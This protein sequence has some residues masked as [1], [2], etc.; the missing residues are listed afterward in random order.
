[1][2]PDPISAF[3]SALEDAGLIP[4]E[5]I[6]DGNLHRCPTRGKEHRKDGAY[7]LH[8]DP[9]ISGWWQNYRTGASDTW[10]SGDQATLPEEERS[11]LRARIEADKKARQ[12]EDVRRHANARNRAIH[13]LEQARKAPQ[14]HPYLVRKGITPV[15][16]LLV[17]SDKKLVI[18]V[19]DATNSL[20]SLQF[21]TVT[22]E[23]KFLS[24]GKI[25]GCFFPIRGGDGP[26]H[27][28]E[29]YA[30]GA[31]IHAA[32][33]ETVLVAFDC[34]NLQ[35][36]AKAARQIYLDRSIILCADDDHATAIETGKNPGIDKATEAASSIN[37]LLAVP[38]FQDPSGKSD[39]NDLAAA[40]G[41]E[42][43]RTCLGKA[44]L[45]EPTRVSKVTGLAPVPFET[46]TPP[47]IPPDNVP[48]ILR[49]FS[50]ALSE[51]LQVPF[52]LALC[53]ALGTVAIAAQRKIQILI[54]DD[55]AEPLNIYALCPLPPGERKSATV[56]ACKRPLVEW[57]ITKYH[58][59]LD[60]IRDATS[61]RKTLEKA[62]EAKRIL[63]AKT[64]TDEARREIIEEIKTMER[65]LPEI[66]ISPRLLADDFTP[67]ALGMLMER[68]E[69][70][71][72]V[73][74]AE[75][76]LFD[77]LSG[78]Y[79]NGIPNL[80]AVLKFW[81]GESCQI[82]RRGRES[83]FLDDPHLTLVISPQPEIVQGLANRPGF[84]GRGLIGRFL[85]VMPQSRLGRRSVETQSVPPP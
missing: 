64:K 18:P 52:E 35:A 6:A 85:Y 61:E 74:E 4:N 66:P 5:I 23:K 29:G 55:Y 22:G 26:L 67:E 49:D 68:H 77:T 10:T 13:I 48:G 28:V 12:A 40:E 76:G 31:T 42:A 33:G 53:N 36:V 30:T 16:E 45:V 82:D 41:L 11:R 65:V 80:D 69:Q 8:A 17:T 43:V 9:P 51:S 59:L 2:S 72:G 70:R 21:I 27:I 79:S 44:K 38:I 83:I 57:Q 46:M 78:K 39:F 71:I 54:K 47:V 32:T 24:G 25:Q 19:L 84:R 15:G 37:C 75:G 81:S 58:E 14:D 34:G 20:C 62:I 3:R 73:L 63:V 60:I 7:I 50:L 1:M 56:E